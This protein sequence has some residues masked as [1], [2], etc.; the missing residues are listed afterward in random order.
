MEGG[1][2]SAGEE[3]VAGGEGGP[4]EEGDLRVLVFVLFPAPD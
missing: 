4:E 3:C 1:V 2:C